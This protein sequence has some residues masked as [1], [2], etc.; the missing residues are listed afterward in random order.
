M[1]FENRIKFD[2]L[3]KAFRT[4]TSKLRKKRAWLKSD[5]KINKRSPSMPFSNIDKSDR[6]T[7]KLNKRFKKN[8]NLKL[9]DKKNEKIEYSTPLTNKNKIYIPP[10]DSERSLLKPSKTFRSNLSP[11]DRCKNIFERNE[12]N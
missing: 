2:D 7:L 8:S 11:L 5:Q 3:S 6:K 9:L 4:T 1:D 12:L 10:I